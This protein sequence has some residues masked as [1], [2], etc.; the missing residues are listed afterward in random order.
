MLAVVVESVLLVELETQ[1]EEIGI[2]GY[3]TVV[4]VAELEIHLDLGK[5]VFV[6]LFD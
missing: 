3:E 5:I 4:A 1:L 2:G 6:D